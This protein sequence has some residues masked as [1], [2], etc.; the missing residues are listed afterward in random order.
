MKTAIINYND[1]L[2]KYLLEWRK[3]NPNFTFGLRVNGSRDPQKDR[4][5]Q[6][7]WFQ[8]NDSYIFVPLTHQSGGINSTRSVG[9]VL[10][11]DRN[12]KMSVSLEVVWLQ[13]ANTDRVKVYHE[14][15]KKVGGFNKIKEEKYIKP[16]G[17]PANE[18]EVL[19][20]LGEFLRNTYPQILSIFK[21]NPKAEMIIPN[22]KFAKALNK[23]YSYKNRT[24][25]DSMAIKNLDNDSGKLNKILY[26]P[27]GTG[28]TYATIDKALKLVL[29]QAEYEDIIEQDREVR[30]NR[31]N[32]LLINPKDKSNQKGQIAFTTFHQSYAY[33]DFIEGIKPIPP[34]E[35]SNGLQYEVRDGIF[36]IIADMARQSAAGYAIMGEAEFLEKARFVKVNL[37][38]GN[39]PSSDLETLDFFLRENFVCA[40]HNK[41]EKLQKGSNSPAI[42]NFIDS[43][44]NDTYFIITTNNDTIVSA[45]GK[46]VGEYEYFDDNTF[47]HRRKVQW[48]ETGLHV[49]AESVYSIDNSSGEY[50][51]LTREKVKKEY[52]VTTK[53]PSIKNYVLI[54]DEINRG[55]IA[56]IFGEL[57]TLIEDTKR[58][59]SAEQ[60]Q[61][62]LPYSQ[63]LFSVPQNLYIIGTMNTADRSVEALDSALRRRFYFEELMPNKD[64]IKENSTVEGIDLKELLTRINERLEV[65]LSKEHTIG[66]T[67]FLNIKELSLL[68]S[69]FKN[70]IIP[71]LKEYFYG[72]FGKIALVL[73]EA[74]VYQ[75]GS[76]RTGNDLFMKVSNYD[77]SEDYEDVRPWCFE[78]ID[79]M[80]ASKFISAV[81]GIYEN[82]TQ[83]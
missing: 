52:F 32:S 44:V 2:L 58:W 30:V 1:H 27:P 51:S 55:N 66:H 25:Q 60:L 5:K 24:T 49:A 43:P 19:L 62:L 56:Q 39:F 65:L 42:N 57:I 40:F 20:L 9:W 69:A 41:V 16:L 67:Y 82:Q 78:D 70:K 8:G 23:I 76:S 61:L 68:R 31:F 77:A 64:E 14:I 59:G 38:S 50:V 46:A 47:K 28:K 75:N 71:L 3:T 74:F 48:L 35:A 17:T 11:F 81:K 29:E 6:G 4:L 73:G 26:G 18:T 45:I 12:G 22:D 53:K 80:D 36:K 21:A 34:A 15:I 79:K 7:Y 10:G 13:E 72:D 33:E 37:S 83:Q 63:K 54:I